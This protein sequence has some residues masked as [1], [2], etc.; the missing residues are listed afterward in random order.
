[1]CE[2]IHFY[3][4][5]WVKTI[6][7]VLITSFDGMFDYFDRCN[8]FRGNVVSVVS[9]IDWKNN[10]IIIIIL[11]NILKCRQIMRMCFLIYILTHRQNHTQTATV[12]VLEYVNCWV[13]SWWRSSFK[14]RHKRLIPRHLVTAYSTS[15]MPF[16]VSSWLELNLL[17]N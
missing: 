8:C 15:S 12:N 3:Q 10:T 7:E 14:S 9:N 11:P 13:L 4:A 6:C 17:W 1:M 2:V 16:E 5:Y